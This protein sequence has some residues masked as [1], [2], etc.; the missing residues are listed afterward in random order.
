MNKKTQLLPISIPGKRYSFLPKSIIADH[1]LEATLVITPYYLGSVSCIDP[2]DI[3]DTEF[4]PSISGVDSW[5]LPLAV[6]DSSDDWTDD[7]KIKDSDTDPPTTYAYSTINIGITGSLI[8]YTPP[9]DAADGMYCNS[10]RLYVYTP[11]IST[12]P[13][14]KIEIN[15]EPGGV[16]ET[17]SDGA[18]CP[19]DQW[20]EYDFDQVEF[21]H[22]AR[23]TFDRGSVADS[24]F[25]YELDFGK[26][27]YE[28]IQMCSDR[29]T[30]EPL[31][32]A[33]LE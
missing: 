10:I 8:L 22:S 15:H 7:D 9:R 25:F 32:E 27:A 6:F 17:L 21:V 29:L 28:K 4:V 3:T 26:P 18:A 30:T 11:A 13:T 5:H 2:V 31:F 14:V 1:K 24:V 12:G 20:N 16:F 19:R 33:S 23:I